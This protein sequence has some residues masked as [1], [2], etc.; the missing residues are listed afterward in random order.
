MIHGDILE[1]AEKECV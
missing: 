1:I